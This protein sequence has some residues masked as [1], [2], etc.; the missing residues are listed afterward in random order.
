[1]R[2]TLT[3]TDNNWS[4]MFV[5]FAFQLKW[6]ISRTRAKIFLIR[7]MMAL[8]HP[9]AT[10]ITLNDITTRT[11]HGESTTKKAPIWLRRQIDAMPFDFQPDET[12]I[13]GKIWKMRKTHFENFVFIFMGTFLHLAH[14]TICL[15]R[16][17]FGLGASTLRI[18]Q[19][20]F[21]EPKFTLERHKTIQKEKNGK[22]KPTIKRTMELIWPNKNEIRQQCTAQQKHWKLIVKRFAKTAV[23]TVQWKQCGWHRQWVKCVRLFC[24]LTLGINERS[25]EWICA[26]K[27]LRQKYRLSVCVCV[28]TTINRPTVSVNRMNRHRYRY[29][30]LAKMKSN[31]LQ[32]I[33]SIFT[34]AEWCWSRVMAILRIEHAKNRPKRNANISPC[35]LIEFAVQWRH[36]HGFSLIDRAL[37]TP[38]NQFKLSHSWTPRSNW[39]VFFFSLSASRKCISA[40]SSERQVG[41]RGSSNEWCPA[42][43]G[44][45][46]MV[47]REREN[48]DKQTFLF[49]HFLLFF[50]K[51]WTDFGKLHTKMNVESTAL[52]LMHVRV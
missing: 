7:L 14:W 10:T 6:S 26:V 22:I 8:L 3:L 27:I 23:I 24:A 46:F 29:K 18:N 52:I 31:C 17:L 39:V 4:K 42:H 30:V 20:H 2:R 48:L 12:T 15:A 32:N 36:C 44:P 16:M 45:P 33:C 13:E 40:I 21:D 28:P 49:F 5:S 38:C 50:G 34:L 19:H 37:Q 1:M 47:P 43:N 35:R 25:D 11:R 9:N 41:S 51:F